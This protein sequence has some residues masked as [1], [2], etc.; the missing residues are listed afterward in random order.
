MGLLIIVAFT[1]WFTGKKSIQGHIL[2]SDLDWT[3]VIWVTFQL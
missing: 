3:I 1:A 2:V